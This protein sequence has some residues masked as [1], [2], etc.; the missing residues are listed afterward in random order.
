MGD[1]ASTVALV[2]EDD[3][4]LRS[5]LVGELQSDGWLVLEAASGEEALALLRAYHVDVVLT[6]IELGGPLNGWDVGQAS[7]ETRRELPIIYTSGNATDRSRRVRGSLFFNKPYD[8]TK[9]V[10]A[11]HQL[12][13]AN[14]R[15]GGDQPNFLSV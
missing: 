5:D 3:V 7:R 9:I 13:D 8:A 6:D 10:E 11:C 4:F 1:Y 14:H 2:V 15:S 12:S